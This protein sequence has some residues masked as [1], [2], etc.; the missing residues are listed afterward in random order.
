MKARC[1]LDNF[2]PALQ[3]LKDDPGSPES[4]EPWTLEQV[5]RPAFVRMCFLV[6]EPWL[7]LLRI[8]T[9]SSPTTK[10]LCYGAIS[11][12][13]IGY[14]AVHIIYHTRFLRDGVDLVP[15][16]GRR[17]NRGTRSN[18]MC[19]FTWL[20]RS[21]RVSNLIHSNTPNAKWDMYHRTS[22]QV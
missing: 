7:L 10:G 21:S 15:Y 8:W 16:G 12:R 9:N 22:Y 17:S 4:I 5:G 6:I 18:G 20:V 1:V 14:H 19:M 2:E 3:M 13:P 11:K